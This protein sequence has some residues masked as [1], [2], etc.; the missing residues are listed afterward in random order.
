MV[1]GMSEES[2]FV[3]KV[4][5]DLRRENFSGEAAARCCLSLLAVV[6]TKDW[7]RVKR[8]SREGDAEQ[9]ADA[10]R[11]AAGTAAEADVLAGLNPETLRKL[12]SVFDKIAKWEMQAIRTI[13]ELFAGRAAEGYQTPAPVAG[14]IAEIARPAE[15]ATLFDPAA[16][17]GLVLVRSALRA[18]EASVRVVGWS[19]PDGIADPEPWR[20]AR[21][22][23][24]VSGIRDAEVGPAPLLDEYHTAAAPPADVVVS[25]LIQVPARNLRTEWAPKVQGLL[26]NLT[27]SRRLVVLV[28]SNSLAKA[29]DLRESLVD[30]GA[31]AAVIRLP[32]GQFPR[33]LHD[34]D[35]LALRKEGGRD[36]DGAVLFVDMAAYLAADASR[37]LDS[38]I[39]RM[40]GDIVE[41]F[42]SGSDAWKDEPVARFARAVPL[43]EI[44]E[45][46]RT[47][48]GS[49]LE[50]T[51]YVP[52]VV[53]PVDLQAELERLRA[54]GRE[55]QMIEADL[56]RRIEAVLSRI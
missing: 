52:P 12:V 13:A 44:R 1:P 26:A 36:A 3:T 51:L 16:R 34:V 54:I 55:R 27:W 9:V 29:A 40:V 5:H 47:G 46:Q 4:L 6:K 20:V 19:F 37:S 2:R 8:A 38:R 56:E 10:V 21:L 30:S 11:Q 24:L 53:E 22:L 14:L 31:L 7:S 28:P 33:L 18:G 50:V 15:G 35:L 42:Q 39:S 23:L 45:R 48:T 25:D 49:E 41:A 32:S 43:S 17:T